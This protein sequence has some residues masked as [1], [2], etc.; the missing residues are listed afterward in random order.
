M[1]KPGGG[2]RPHPEKGPSP[3][4][5]LSQPFPQ[6]RDG[7]IRRPDVPPVARFLL[8]RKKGTV[9]SMRCLFEHVPP[10]MFRTKKAPALQVRGFLWL[11]EG[12]SFRTRGNRTESRQGIGQSSRSFHARDSGA[13]QK[14]PG[15]N[16]E[17][18][19][20][21]WDGGTACAPPPHRSKFLRVGVRGRELFSKSSLPRFALHPN[22]NIM[23]DETAAPCR[24]E[25]SC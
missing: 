25:P 20:R 12:G 19:F 15:N 22:R 10:D 13:R 6:R 17:G 14:R 9:R 7:A 24:M 1:R 8:K 4:P 11:R 18:P 21:A 3:P 2:E 16:P 23:Q 5:G